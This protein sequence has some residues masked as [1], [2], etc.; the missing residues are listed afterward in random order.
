MEESDAPFSI[1]K[2][3]GDLFNTGALDRETMASYILTVVAHDG[4]PRNSLS[5][6]ATVQVIVEDVNDNSPQILYG[7]YVANVPSELSKGKSYL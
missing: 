6:S 5:G 1:N 7:P 4:D 3:S 2:T